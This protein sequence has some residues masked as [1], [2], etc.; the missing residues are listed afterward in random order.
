MT[1]ASEAGRHSKGGAVAQ[2]HVGLFDT[3][4]TRRQVRFSVAIISLLFAILLVLLALPSYQLREINLIVPVIDAILLMSDLIIAT[5]LYAQASIFRSRALTVLASG[6]VFIATLLVAHILTYPGGFAPDGLLG[7]EFD[8]AGWIFLYR[9]AA[10]P[11]IVILYVFLRR[12]EQSVPPPEP[13]PSLFIA[14]GAIAG[15]ALA[16]AVTALTITQH[17]LLPPLFI[18]RFH[19]DRATLVAAN[20][21]LIGL[22]L[23]AM[24]CLFWQRKS[25]LDLWLLVALSA[26]LMQLPLS[27]GH[28][29]RF[30]LSY[31][32]QF[33]LM[34]TSNLILM[35]ALIAE[36]GRLYTRLALA[37]AARM[38]ER[39]ALLMTMSAT[40]AMFS[41][42]IG[43]PLTA[44]TTNAKAGLNYLTR[45]RPDVSKAIEALHASLDAGK[46]TVGVIRSLRAMAAKEPG[47]FTEFDLNAVVR[48]AADLLDREL[49]TAKVSLK[50]DL[51][52]TVP[53]VQADRV[54]VQQVLV[55]LLVN[56]IESIGETRSRTRRITIRSAPV[57]DRAVLLE[58]SD[59]GR[60]IAP[61]DLE[62]IFETFVTTKATGTGLG[63]PISRILAEEQGG[64]LWA[65]PGNGRS[66]A[67]FHL[68][69]PYSH[70]APTGHAS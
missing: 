29:G 61:E 57:D 47:R 25:V 67:T 15:V 8:T 16:V 54:Q 13:K 18:D 9:R 33:A 42:E 50:L 1:P 4:P 7:A 31:Y 20:S 52:E 60:G 14:W 53:P 40:A 43:Q 32:A 62:R 24:A 39:D 34:P 44:V 49:V 11:I 38:R 64:R 70:G 3:P 59:T 48:E 6:F 51:D 19:I 66:G 63:L 35:F 55:N 17:N 69:L 68:Q 46:L 56:A 2:D 45:P 65:V 27:L 23:A 5:L 58:V 36:S 12:G 30:T 22:V 41:H 26:W 28:W 21:V 37:T 10:L